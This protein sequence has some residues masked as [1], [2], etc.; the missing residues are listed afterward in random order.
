MNPSYVNT[1]TLVHELGHCLDLLH[2][3]EPSCCHETCN[4][5][6]PEYLYDLFG[7]N[8]PSYC[9][10]KGHFG[11]KI[12]PGENTCT[13]N[14]MGGNNML[15]YYFSPM[16]MGKM[17]RSLSIKSGKK[18]VKEDV[19]DNRVCK[20]KENETWNFDIRCYSDIIV[21][22]GATLTVTGKITMP[23]QG[24]IVVKRGAK[25]IV[26]G[27]IITGIRQKWGGME[28]KKNRNGIQHLLG[29]EGEIEL[30]NGAVIENTGKLGK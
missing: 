25:L 1:Q 4:I 9:W 26:D 20:I 7:Y 15:H 13:N 5:S 21:E 10:E 18:Y 14:I 28:I 22:R 12:T 6:D 27:G 30:K 19:Y 3:Y 24:K 16:Q 23:E 11:C 29:R 17:H 2:T 8:P